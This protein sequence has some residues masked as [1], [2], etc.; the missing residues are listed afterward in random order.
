[1]NQPH[2]EFSYDSIADA[3]AAS[4][5]ESPYNALYE[6]PAVLGLMPSV[7]GKRILEAGCGAG[8]YTEQLLARGA[9]VTAI[10]E[11]AA[12]VEHA[13]RRI[14]ALPHAARERAEV[15]VADLREPL[16]F[17]ADASQDGI[18]SALV[19]HYLRDWGPVM[20]EFRRVLAPG[21]WLLF[22]THH[23]G[24]DASRL[25]EG[26]NYFD[27]VQQEDH[28][29]RVGVVRFY[30]RPLM[31]IS[32]ALAGAGFGIERIVEPRPGDD[33]RQAHPA[34]YA[35]LIRQPEFLLVLA[36]PWR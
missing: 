12:M 14:A 26:E 30:R 29:K 7:G 2:V 17:A 19:L 16:S 13:R 11:S 33:F 8:W 28:W 23:P 27:V 1:M 21:G 24:A 4:I 34:A 6:R 35:R 10:D 5:D 22:S 20:A 18:V 15:R 9:R 3:Y 32:D 25:P 36:R 31:A